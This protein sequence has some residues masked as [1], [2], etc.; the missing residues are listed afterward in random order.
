MAKGGIRHNQGSCDTVVRWPIQRPMNN[1]AMMEIHKLTRLL[2][3]QQRVVTSMRCGYCGGSVMKIN[4]RTYGCAAHKDRG[5]AVCGGVEAS[6][7]DVDHVV[8][9]YVR[10]VLA[11]P[12]CTRW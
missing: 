3:A 9:G 11:A 5:P 6:F 2:S 10:G 1:L 4:A 8:V 7:R 12:K